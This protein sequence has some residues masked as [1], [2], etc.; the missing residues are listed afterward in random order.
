MVHVQQLSP[1]N[2]MWVGGSSTSSLDHGGRGGGGILLDCGCD[3][4]IENIDGVIRCT[5]LD[6]R[7]KLDSNLQTV[8]VTYS[9]FYKECFQILHADNSKHPRG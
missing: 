9:Y 8:K 3:K 6:R 5:L 2:L 7:K 4:K 1:P